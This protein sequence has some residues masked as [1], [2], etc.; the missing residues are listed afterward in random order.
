MNTGV[1][2][3]EGQQIGAD[4]LAAEMRAKR[5]QQL[6]QGRREHLE[7]SQE[8]VAA[9]LDMSSRAY[10]NWERGR[11]KEWTDQKLYALAHALEMTEFQTTRLFWIAVD[12]APQPDLRAITRH[13][14]EEDPRTSAFLVD[15]SVMMDALSLPT[16]LIDHRWD[17]KRANNAYLKLFRNVRLH[18]TAMP[19]GNFLRFGL[20][21]PDAP[22]ILVD[23]MT[24]RLSMLAQLASTLERHDQDPV[25]QAIR[26]E[27]YVHP[28]LRDAYL[29]DMPN[30]VLG[31]G[32]DLVHHEGEVRE[33]RHPDPH[34]GLQGC[35]L[36]EE[37]PRP[38]QARGLSRITLVLTA[39]N[40]RTATSESGHG[41]DHHAA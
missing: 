36:V 26:R 19:T 7:L 12:R 13:P 22:S 32:A 39:L 14:S 30:W 31:A 34:L 41:H 4:G 18:S 10:G 29:N 11:V 40:D 28:A 15:Y 8:D 9:R 23:H 25:L 20:F 35:R 27:V 21:H 2:I 24:W 16:V 17:V 5:L 38:L 3:D 37:T 1:P 33:L 6:L